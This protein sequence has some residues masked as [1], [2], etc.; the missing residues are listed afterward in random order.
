MLSSTDQNAPVPQAPTTRD[1]WNRR[2]V[3][4]RI[5]LILVIL[6]GLLFWLSSQIIVVLLIFLV[7]ALLAYAIVPVI[8][9]LH[10]FMPRAL[11]IV[12]VYLV[13]IALFGF[14]AYITVKTLIPQMNSLAQSIQTSVTPGK[15][16]QESPLDQTASEPGFFPEPDQFCY[17]T[18][19]VPVEF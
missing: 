6:A 19:S 4:L 15:N 16:G 11:A 18:S 9:R 5:I 7:A 12:L 14:F 1:E 3:F 8:D 17:K 10:R 13:A 2:L